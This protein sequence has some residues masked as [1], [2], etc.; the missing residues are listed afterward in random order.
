MLQSLL[1]L[2]VDNMKPNDI[3]VPTPSSM[4]PLSGGNPNGDGIDKNLRDFLLSIKE[5]I[6]ESTN[7]A[8]NRINKR[9]DKAE[10][11]IAILKKKVETMGNE[12]DKKIF[13]AVKAEVAKLSVQASLPAQSKQ[14]E[15]YSF[16]RRSLKLWPISGN[17][18]LDGVK[19]FL[20]SRLKFTD[21]RIESLG[22]IKVGAAPG[23]V[24]KERREVLVT[25]QTM[26]DRDF[27]KASGFNLSGRTSAGMSLHVPDCLVNK[28]FA[29]NSVAYKIKVNHE[30][31][32]RS[33]K[34]DDQL[35]DIYLDIFVGG[36]WKRI[37]SMMA[38][39]VVKNFPGF[40][41]N[42]KS[43]STDNL[44][45]LVRKKPYQQTVE[46]TLAEKKTTYKETLK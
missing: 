25:F 18:V 1:S 12:V 7:A 41:F 16:C 39:Q 20:R 11:S 44:A 26:E 15:D 22:P 19:V 6:K 9:I 33:V 38:L 17:D 46:M 40:T 35:Q 43:I 8:I 37:S 14:E 31:V 23:R 21:S 30:G 3:D 24:A 34:F 10:D 4:A 29:L 5:D 13:M 2:Q 45:C 28:L 32:K 27:V 42:D 36:Q